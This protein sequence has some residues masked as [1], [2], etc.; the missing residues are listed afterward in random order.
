MIDVTQSRREFLK[1]SAAAAALIA[2]P[3]MAQPQTFP[4]RTI[5]LICPWPV[6]GPTDIVM[7]AFA[8]RAGKILGGT[9]IIDNKPGATG[10]LGA[11]E[12]VNAKPDG[13]T[14][15][16]LPIGIFR[17]PHMQKTQFDPLKDLTYIACLTGYTF[18]LVVRADS[19]ITSIKE[20][21]AY[22]KANPEKFAY[23][24]PGTGSTPHLAMEQFSRRAGIKMLHIPFKGSADG[25]QALLGGHVMGHSDSTGWAPHV[26]S[27][28]CRLLATYGSKRTK[29]WPN[30]LT[31]QEL[32]Y[33]TVSDSP[34]GIG[35]PK[36]MDPALIRQLQDVFKKTLD[37]AAVQATLDKYDQ[38]VIYLD[39]AA[40][41]KFARDTYAAEKETIESLGLAKPA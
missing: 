28:R 16:Q 19:P 13:Y 38:P 39:S 2:C 27:G 12:L 26:D 22:G 5:K 23:G 37:D 34:F 4:S 35:A 24:S 15:S 36:G 3:A 21:V 25:M 1:T 8:E 6:G 11:I 29:R 31:L 30:V 20:L 32:G 33:Q 41:T 40:Y 14:L 17:V 10:T 7:R 18:G 9:M